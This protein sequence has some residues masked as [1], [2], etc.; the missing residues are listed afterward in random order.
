MHNLI[1]EF[2]EYINHFYNFEVGIYPLATSKEITVSI[3]IYFLRNHIT[4]I[5][6][7]SVDREKVKEIIIEVIKLK[8]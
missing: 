8:N 3:M 6:F 2:E 7:D 1:Q 4:S 5:D